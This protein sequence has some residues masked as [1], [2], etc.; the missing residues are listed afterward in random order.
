MDGVNLLSSLGLNH[1]SEVGRDWCR[2]MG[3]AGTATP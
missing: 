1:S 3:N 2:E